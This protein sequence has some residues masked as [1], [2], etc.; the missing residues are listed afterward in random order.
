MSKKKNTKKKD[1]KKDQKKKETSVINIPVVP[2]EVNVLDIDRHD[3]YDDVFKE[4][5]TNQIV[6]FE[7][8][9]RVFTFVCESEIELRVEVLSATIVRFR[10]NLGNEWAEDFS[11]ARD[12][13]FRA[14]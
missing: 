6:S 3:R 10:Y 11:Y 8:S 9:N 2:S 12:A 5:F 7:K 1:K 13:K 14:K 4:W